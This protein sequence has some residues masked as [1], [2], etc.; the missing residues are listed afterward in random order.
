MVHAGESHLLAHLKHSLSSAMVSVELQHLQER[1]SVHVVKMNAAVGDC[2]LLEIQ[3]YF[4]LVMDHGQEVR[5][6]WMKL[7]AVYQV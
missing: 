7:T 2:Y 5:P 6:G 3:Q 4:H 1:R